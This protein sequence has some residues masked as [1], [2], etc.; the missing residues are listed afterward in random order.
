MA[1][2]KQMTEIFGDSKVKANVFNAL[3]G[4]AFRFAELIGATISII[5][6]RTDEATFERDGKEEVSPLTYIIT[7]D[8]DVYYTYSKGVYRSVDT[9]L[10]VMGTADKWTEPIRVKVSKAT[11]GR[12]TYYL[13][14]IV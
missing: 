2:Y 10:Q 13:M 12:G 1:K 7:S 14:N 6:F 11:N 8:Y 5:G 9:I 3:Q 4:E